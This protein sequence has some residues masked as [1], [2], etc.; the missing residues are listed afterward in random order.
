MFFLAFLYFTSYF[1]KSFALI[2]RLS[3]SVALIKSVVLIFNILAIKDDGKIS[4]ALIKSYLFKVVLLL[5]K[6]PLAHYFNKISKLI[7]KP[8]SMINYYFC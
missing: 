5:N 7:I 2:G 3:C 8:P 4:T 1:K 6:M